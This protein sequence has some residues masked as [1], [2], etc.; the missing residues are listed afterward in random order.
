MAVKSTAL[1]DQGARVPPDSGATVLGMRRRVAPPLAASLGLLALPAPA[2]AHGLHAGSGDQSVPGYLWLGITHMIGGWDHLLFIA[3]LV[4]LAQTAKGAAKLISL[5]VAGHSLTLLVATL[6]GWQLDAAGVDVLIAASVAF[7]GWRILVGRPQRWGPTLVAIFAFGLVHGL[8]LSTR[9]QELD[10]PAGG[11]LVA[12]IL[13]FNV[14]VELGQ[15]AAL[16]VIGAAALLV[17][18]GI[19]DLDAA[20]RLTAA[21]LV[22]TGL[23]ASFTLTFLAARPDPTA[24]DA[25]RDEASTPRGETCIERTA[26]PQPAALDGAHPERSFYP[27]GQAPDEQDLRHVLGD[28]FLI[29]RYDPALP[30]RSRQE[31]AD[32]AR[33]RPLGV[34]IT[35]AR[36]PSGQVEAMTRERA[37]ACEQLEVDQLT[38]L[39]D[40]WFA[41]LAP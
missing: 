35:P 28:S 1:P 25:S 20:R 41:T 30:R 6:A 3:G 2:V 19:R 26:A 29:V 31:L 37:L 27:P 24:A 5:F 39:R 4:V 11:A 21:C 9:L 12:R 7:V 16:A 40:R 32:W 36:R 34:V 17:V 15:L 33:A 22:A 13:A 38:A 14:G 8:G 18:R 10:L 23:I